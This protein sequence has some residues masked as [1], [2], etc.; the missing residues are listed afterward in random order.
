MGRHLPITPG[1]WTFES[2]HL[3]ATI[4][5]SYEC[6]NKYQG[7]GYNFLKVKEFTSEMLFYHIY[8]FFRGSFRTEDEV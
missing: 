7:H 8:S 5:L 4:C 3:Q 1:A 6:I 2:D